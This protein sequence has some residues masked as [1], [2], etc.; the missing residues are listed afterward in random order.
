MYICFL[1]CDCEFTR[2]VLYEG[3]DEVQLLSRY[4]NPK[5]VSLC[6]SGQGRCRIIQHDICHS[7][8]LIDH[9]YW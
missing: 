2:E 5:R 8:H 4:H 6:K 3:W 1:G 7:Q 9:K